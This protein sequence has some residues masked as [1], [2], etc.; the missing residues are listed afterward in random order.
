MTNDEI[1]KAE[2]KLQAEY[3]HTAQILDEKIAYWYQ[4]FAEAEGMTVDEAMKT[5]STSER[6]KFEMTLK[7]YIKAGESLNDNF[8]QEWLDQMNQQLQAAS[9]I[10]HI[11]RFTALKYTMRQEI[12]MLAGKQTPI[13]KNAMRTA[14]TDARGYSI[15]SF[16][17]ACGIGWSVSG[18]DTK[19]LETLLTQVW[20]P[21]Q[22]SFSDHIWTNKAKLYS[23][24]ETML[25]ESCVV[26]RPYDKVAKDLA[27]KMGVGYNNARR[28]V[29]TEMAHFSTEGEMA[30]YEELGVERYIY[31]ATL[32]SVTCTRCAE[33]DGKDFP[34]DKKEEG[35]NAPPMHP[36][37]RCVTTEYMPESLLR[38]T[39]AARNKE[40]KTIQIPATMNYY[41]WKEKFMTEEPA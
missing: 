24:I 35:L 28:L 4:Q 17:S 8:D 25:S 1:Q 11:D 34:V 40:G 41:D 19:K 3:E 39:R 2:A 21:D 31:V 15:F 16:E 27:A 23:S 20:S 7:E 33:L 30:A 29:R 12:E 37:C 18:A 14:Y 36:N 32:D 26:G 5:L 10:H 6:K 22:R 13:I 38:S 9:S